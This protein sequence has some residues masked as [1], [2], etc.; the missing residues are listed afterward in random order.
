MGKTKDNEMKGGSYFFMSKEP[1]THQH[2]IY[3]ED[4]RKVGINI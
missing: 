2:H 1:Q 4:E 3:Y